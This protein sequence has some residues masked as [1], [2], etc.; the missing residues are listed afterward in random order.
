MHDRV[1]IIIGSEVVK[2]TW[3]NFIESKL[4]LWVNVFRLYDYVIVTID[5]IVH[6]IVT[7]SMNK[8]VLNIPLVNA[9]VALQRQELL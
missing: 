3:V 5:M 4:V 8:L 9:D 7:Q 2:K 1:I 6:V